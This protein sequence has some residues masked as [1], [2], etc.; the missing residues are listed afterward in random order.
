MDACHDSDKSVWPLMQQQCSYALGPGVNHF[1]VITVGI[2]K[3][4]SIKLDLI[5]Q[6]LPKEL[7]LRAGRSTSEISA[8]GICGFQEGGGEKN[9][10]LKSAYV[11][12]SVCV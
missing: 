1:N 5:D 4:P 8:Q 7:P 9:L 11:A 2:S 12:F 6:Q 10:N 3:A